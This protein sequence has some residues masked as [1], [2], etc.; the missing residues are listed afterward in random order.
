MAPAG[1]AS[2][3]VARRGL[4]WAARGRRP[5]QSPDD[6]MQDRCLPEPWVA[7]AFEEKNRADE[8]FIFLDLDA[9]D[10]R[11]DRTHEAQGLLTPIA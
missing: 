1:E 8:G 4:G 11:T 7:D 6:P 9:Q 2:A 3:A 5:K 10:G